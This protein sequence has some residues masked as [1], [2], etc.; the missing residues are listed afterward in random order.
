M[1]DVQDKPSSQGLPGLG[2][3]Y[4]GHP[5]S[6]PQLEIPV[7]LAAPGYQFLTLELESDTKLYITLQI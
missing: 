5:L 2:C 3:S 1:G 7:S 6:H 4:P